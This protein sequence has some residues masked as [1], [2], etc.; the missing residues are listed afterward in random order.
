[1]A[2]GIDRKDATAMAES[3]LH[4]ERRQRSGYPAVQ[5]CATSPKRSGRRGARIITA[6]RGWPHEGAQQ[7]PFSPSTVLPQATTAGATLTKT[8]W[9]VTIEG[10]FGIITSNFRLP[11]T[12][13][14]SARARQSRANGKHPP[15]FAPEKHKSTFFQDTLQ[16]GT[17]G[18]ARSGR[19]FWQPGRWHV[20]SA[21]NSARIQS[22]RDRPGAA[23]PRNTVASQIGNFCGK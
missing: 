9:Q 19:K 3:P 7:Q 1:M 22:R 4:S 23:A 2:D 10:G 14:R 18:S 8:G 15:G 6:R 13:T 5:R 20:P 11:L 21:E 16:D 12:C 17:E